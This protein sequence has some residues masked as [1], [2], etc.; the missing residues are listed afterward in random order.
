MLKNGNYHDDVKSC[1]ESWFIIYGE[2]YDGMPIKSVFTNTIDH[3]YL[4]YATGNESGT[5]THD[6]EI[7]KDNVNEDLYT[8]VDA[9][10]KFYADTDFRTDAYYHNYER[11]DVNARCNVIEGVLWEVL[12]EHCE[13]VEHKELFVWR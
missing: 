8:V 13:E 5:F 11:M 2:D 3:L 1:V 4:E 6:R 10:L 12:Y 7:A 9:Y